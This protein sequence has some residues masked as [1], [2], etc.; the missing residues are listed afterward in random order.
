MGCFNLLIGYWFVGEGLEVI[1]IEGDSVI[2]F[3]IVGVGIFLGFVVFGV[4]GS[5]SYGSVFF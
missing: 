3:G 2:M 1:F 4:C 5:E